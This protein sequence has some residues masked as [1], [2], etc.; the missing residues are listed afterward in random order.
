MKGHA[1]DKQCNADEPSLREGV[2][3]LRT[4]EKL[5]ADWSTFPAEERTRCIKSIEWF[6]PTYT[7]LIACTEMYGQVRNLRE[8]RLRLHRTVRFNSPNI[9]ATWFACPVR[10]ADARANTESRN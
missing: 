1:N 9:P 7:E 3:G 10:N 5:A 4:R 2:N 8:T 6:S